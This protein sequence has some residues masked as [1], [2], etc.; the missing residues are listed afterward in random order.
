MGAPDVF[1]RVVCGVDPSGAGLEAVRQASTL[2]RPGSELV[3]VGVSES[4]LAAQA[5]MLATH[6]AAQL[7]ARAREALDDAHALVP[8]A[9]PHFVRGRPDDVLLQIS[10]E[11]RATLIAV[12]SHERRRMTG[13]L[14]GGVATRMLHDAPCSVLLAR[15]RETGTFPGSIVA[16]VDGSLASL[17]A[18]AVAREL[19]DRLGAPSRVL[20]ADDVSPLDV[21][22]GALERSGLELERV[23]ARPVPALLEASREAGLVVLGSRGLRGIGALGSV[24][25]RV[26]HQAHCSL[27]V[28]RQPG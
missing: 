16:G 3:L 11:T 12:G 7:E 8:E 20:V 21:D 22:E 27:L 28:L 1:E 17:W 15:A 23:D 24:S 19:G 2:S 10:E 5:G 4:H 25:E 9:Q 13:I 6:A 26:A 18:A 14:L